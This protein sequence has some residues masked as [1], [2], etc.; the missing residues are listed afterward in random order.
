MSSNEKSSILKGKEAERDIPSTTQPTSSPTPLQELSVDASEVTFSHRFQNTSLPVHSVTVYKNRAEVTRRVTFDS[1]VGTG[2]ISIFGFPGT[3]DSKTIRVKGGKGNAVILEVAYHTVFH[4]TTADEELNK[5]RE[6]QITTLRK[7]LETIEFEQQKINS[8]KARLQEER[9]VLNSYKDKI[10]SSSPSSLSSLFSKDTI[11]SLV[12]WTDLFQK[13]TAELDSQS[14]DLQFRSEEL[15]K[16][17]SD[18]QKSI[19]EKQIP[20]ENK[21]SRETNISIYAP[22]SGEV[23]LFVSYICEGASWESSYDI[24]VSKECK[25]PNVL[26]TYYGNIK[27]NTGEDWNNTLISLSTASPNLEGH[28]P[29]MPIVYLN[30]DYSRNYHGFDEKPGDLVYIDSGFGSESLSYNR[31]ETLSYAP[32]PVP[33]ALVANVSKGSTSSTFSIPRNST[34]ESDNKSHKVTIAIITLPCEF[35][36]HTIPK[37]TPY[38]FL[39]AQTTNNSDFP[40]LPGPS[41]IFLDNNF[42]AD[43]KIKSVSTGETFSLYLGIDAGVR[44]EFKNPHKFQEQYGL[45]QKTEST[46]SEYLTLIKNTKSTPVKLTLFDQLPKS[47]DDKI[48]V[49]IIEPDLRNAENV[50]LNSIDSIVEWEVEIEPGQEI[51]IPFRYSIDVS[52]GSSVRF[53]EVSTDEQ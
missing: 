9:K 33:S 13:H 12:Q 24:R 4:V 43:S 32:A 53:Y 11:S 48:K 3:V 16:K 22:T 29:S 1:T 25:E 34:V 39:H 52:V 19:A 5:E 17:S 28:P 36:Y 49:K 7:E 21:V 10:L 44:V 14:R 42:V 46:T 50:K 41:K 37:L 38:A 8:T 31:K 2:E 47:D 40:L 27:Q 45:L 35:S 26:V 6:S 30:F 15:T 51:R 20:A 18:L 23:V